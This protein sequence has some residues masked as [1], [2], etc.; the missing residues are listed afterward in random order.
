MSLLRS[1]KPM[2]IVFLLMAGIVAVWIFG[3]TYYSQHIFHAADHKYKLSSAS[4][5]NRLQY[6]SST[7]PLIEVQPGQD[8]QAQITIA[9]EEYV[10]EKLLDHTDS[11]DSQEDSSAEYLVTYPDGEVYRVS[12]SAGRL[13]AEDSYGNTVNRH[14]VYI[15]GVRKLAEGE[16]Y[17]H[18][19]A[20]VQAA[21][22]KHQ[23]LQGQRWLYVLSILLLIHG[24]CLFL[25]ERYQTFWF[26]MSFEWIYVKNPQPSDFYYFST[27]LGGIFTVAVSFVMFYKSL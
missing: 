17:Y 13:T 7:G 24:C 22:E 18:P 25:F 11:P 5:P 4:H 10:V 2:V 19:V 9:K 20:F 26:W 16:P 27:K 15:G 12:E 23:P 21:D 6:S 1:Y 3:A 14:S 8:N